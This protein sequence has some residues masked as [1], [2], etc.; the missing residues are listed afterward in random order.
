[1]PAYRPRPSSGQRWP[2]VLVVQEIF[3]VHT[4]IQDVCRRLAVH[5]LLLLKLCAIG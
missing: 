5:R 2:V 3:G 4:H 1:M